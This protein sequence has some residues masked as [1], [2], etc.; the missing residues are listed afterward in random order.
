MFKH[1]TPSLCIGIFRTLQNTGFILEGTSAADRK[2]TNQ[3]IFIRINLIQKT[4]F[5]IYLQHCK[6]I[7]WYSLTIHPFYG[8]EVYERKKKYN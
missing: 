4:R 8:K 3:W 5:N 1:C 6:V 7:A 2:Q